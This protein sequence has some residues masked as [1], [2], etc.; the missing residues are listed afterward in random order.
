MINSPRIFWHEATANKLLQKTLSQLHYSEK[1][2]ELLKSLTGK[3]VSSLSS[4]CDYQN[5]IFVFGHMR[6]GSTA[7]TNVLCSHESIS[8]YGEA[9]IRYHDRSGPGRLLVNQ[10]L[11]WA[12]SPSA[13]YLCDKIL[14]N[15]Y[16]PD[17]RSEYR[18]ARAIFSVR[19]PSPTILSI[20]NLFHSIGKNEYP[21][22]DDAA[23]YYIERCERLCSLWDAFEVEQRIGIET[24]DLRSRPDETISR[25]SSFLDLNPVLRNSYDSKAASRKKGGGDP[26]ESAKHNRIVQASSLHKYGDMSSLDIGSDLAERAEAIHMEIVE[27]FRADV[28]AKVS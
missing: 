27:R 11:R 13:K 7:L 15:R 4:Q 16:D 10:A 8:G 18:S 28:G 19:H 1:M 24:E 20:V 2:K 14:H 17:I 22:L 3:T 25:V 6:S 21:T 23:L 5:L 12:W 9:H 26:L